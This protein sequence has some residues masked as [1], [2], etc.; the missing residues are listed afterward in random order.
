MRSF[1]QIHASYLATDGALS[2]SELA[3]NSARAKARW[4]NLRFYNDQAYYIMLFA[5]LERFIDDECR[6]LIDKKK[7]SPV[8]KNRRLWDS[9]E[10]DRLPFL[11]KVAL[12]TERGSA[13]YNKISQYYDLRC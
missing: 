9:T 5:Q 10:A 11:R 6:N 8:W 3:A 2:G 4:A 13:T 7:K 1:R 12:L